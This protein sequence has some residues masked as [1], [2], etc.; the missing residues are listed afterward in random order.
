MLGHRF[1]TGENSTFDYPTLMRLSSRSRLVS[2]A[3]ILIA[4]AAAAHQVADVKMSVAAPAFVAA[5]QQFTYLIVADDLTN[6]TAEGVVVTATLPP[7]VA[8]VR[9]FGTGW[10]C[11]ESKLTV[12]CSAD[13]IDSGPN[14]IAIDVTA[15]ALPGPIMMLV[16]V[17]STE[18]VDPNAAND[19][20]TAITTVYEPAACPAINLQITQPDDMSGPLASP[21]RLAWTAVPNARRYLVYAAVEG[22]RNAI[23]ATT[24]ATLLSFP[25]ERGNVEWHVEAFLETCPTISSASRRFLS[26]GKPAALT[27]RTFAGHSDRVGNLD[28]SITNATFMSPFGLAVDEAGNLFVAD[29]GSF[30]IR[31]ISDGQVTTPAGNAGVA[32]VA[33]GR[34]GS[35]AGPMGIAYSPIDNFLLI[36]DRGNDVV[37]LR[38]PGDRQLGYVLTIGGAPGL[39]GIVDG[40][41]EVSRFSGPS[42]VAPDPRGRLYVVDS[43]NHRIR[44]LTTVREYVGYYSTETFAGGS[45]GSEDGLA[46]LAQFR[47]PSGIAA[48]GEEI[49]YVADTGNHTIRKI[50][51]GAVTTVAGLPGS[52]G[53]A[54]GY[55]AAARFNEPAAIAVDDR[56]NLY[57]CDTGNHTIRKVSPSGLVTTVAGLAGNP[58]DSEGTGAAA[59]LSSPGGIAFDQNGAIYISD[60]GNHRVVVAHV[61]TAP[62]SDRHRAVKR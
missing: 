52:P 9:A 37:R 2:L 60:T 13:E 57:V 56:G 42:A 31:E 21:V 26:A 14:V 15:P 18:S 55:G 47:N 48:D 41:F 34:P 51:N 24:T 61:E 62:S 27:L 19:T 1:E 16:I 7:S 40:I 33:D 50:V 8:F 28:G 46:T 20:A 29:S 17:Q 11:N 5:R 49:V 23:V 45:E 6:D 30:T 25:F 10:I 58:G 3:M 4:E 53:A 44:K 38:Y 12:T 35:F 22:E 59:R 43:G 32:G 36:A 54:D 39:A